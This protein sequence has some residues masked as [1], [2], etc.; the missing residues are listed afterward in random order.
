MKSS[1]NY[2]ASPRTSIRTT[3]HQAISYLRPQH[4]H[5]SALLRSTPPQAHRALLRLRP[6]QTA[7]H[8][9][10]KAPAPPS[11]RCRPPHRS[12]AMIFRI[13]PILRSP[14][15]ERSHFR[16]IVHGRCTF[17]FARVS[18]FALHEQKICSRVCR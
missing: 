10:K 14:T 16:L 5:A 3:D 4:P 8:T 11:Y 17:R 12:R 6:A 2:T 18:A 15:A 9:A 13:T 7:S 1:R